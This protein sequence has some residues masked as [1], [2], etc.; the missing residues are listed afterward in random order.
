[1][2]KVVFKYFFIDP[3]K[4][5]EINHFFP[6]HDETHTPEEVLTSFITQFYENKNV[7]AE[8]LINKKINDLK[9]IKASLGKKR[10]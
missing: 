4:I 2:Q 3:N 5:G 7:P 1:M 6:K 9:L 8:I 10:G